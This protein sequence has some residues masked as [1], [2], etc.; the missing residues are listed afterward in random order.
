MHAD[1]FFLSALNQ[2]RKKFNWTILTFKY[3][4]YDFKNDKNPMPILTREFA[5]IQRYMKMQT[6]KIVDLIGEW[7]VASYLLIYFN[8]SMEILSTRTFIKPHL[9]DIGRCASL[10]KG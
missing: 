4:F 1:F 5:G 10:I 9:G 3:I 6:T 7:M 2:C 8:F